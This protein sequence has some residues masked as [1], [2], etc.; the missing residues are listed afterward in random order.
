[1]D[2]VTGLPWTTKGLDAIW[3]IED[4]LTKSGHFLPIKTTYNATQYTYL[5]IDEIVNLHGVLVSII[6]NQ[7]LNSPPTFENL[8]MKP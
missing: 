2:F 8:F 6:S 7:G 3:V 5:Y 4:K 1:M